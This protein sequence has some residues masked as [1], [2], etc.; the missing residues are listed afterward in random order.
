MSYHGDLD[1]IDRTTEAGLCDTGQLPSDFA[2]AIETGVHR[3]NS[4]YYA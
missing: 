2:A 4:I 1:A 3:G